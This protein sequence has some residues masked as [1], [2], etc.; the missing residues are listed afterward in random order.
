MSSQTVGIWKEVDMPC[1][2][3]YSTT[4][5]WSAIKLCRYVQYFSWDL[6]QLYPK[7]K[8]RSLLHVFARTHASDPLLYAVI[9]E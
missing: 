1:S 9:A 4:L 7:Y 5:P 8:C 3:V 2:N 6:N